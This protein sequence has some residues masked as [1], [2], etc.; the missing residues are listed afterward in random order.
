M[1]RFLLGLAASAA[2]GT[3]CAVPDQAHSQVYPWCGIT[4]V[5]GGTNCYFLTWHQ[6]QLATSGHGGWCYRNPFSG[7]ARYPADLPRAARKYRH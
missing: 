2:I 3:L 5:G 6:C 7:Y 4:A 1:R